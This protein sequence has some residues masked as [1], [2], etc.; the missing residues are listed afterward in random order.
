[1]RWMKFSI[2]LF[3]T[4]VGILGAFLPVLPSTVFFITAAYFFSQSSEKAEHWL[5][6]H[7]RFGPPVVKWQEERAISKPAKVLA[8][9]GISVSAIIIYFA[10]MPPIA[11]GFAYAVLIGSLAYILSRPS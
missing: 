5:L 11:A 2:G 4:G 7:P 9:T 6:N 10:G 3:F 8:T 1:M